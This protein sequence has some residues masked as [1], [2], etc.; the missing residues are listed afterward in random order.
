MNNRTIISNQ[1]VIKQMTANRNARSLVVN[2][3]VNDYL[4]TRIRLNRYYDDGK[5]L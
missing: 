1:L 2:M 3:D 5:A 4:C